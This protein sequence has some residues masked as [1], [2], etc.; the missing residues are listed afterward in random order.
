MLNQHIIDEFKKNFEYQPTAGQEALMVSLANFVLNNGRR[1][2][3]LIKGYAGTGKTTLLSSF[4][5]TLKT[6]NQKSVLLAPTGRA[7]K[8]FSSYSGTPAFTVHKI[9][10]RQKSST[11]SFGTF[12]LNKN[13]LSNTFFIVDEASMIGNQSY[14]HSIFGSGNLLSDLI[15]FVYNDKNCRLIFIGDTAQLPPVGLDISPALN[16]EVVE[17]YNLEVEEVFLSDVVRQ[18]AES[19]ILFNA[20]EVRNMVS[21][22]KAETPKIKLTG[23]PDIRRIGGAEM[24]DEISSAYDKF[25]IEETMIITRSN[26]RA[27]QFNQGIRSQ[28]LF[29]EEQ[30]TKGDYLMVVKNNYFWSEGN[31][32][33]DFIANGDIVQITAI[34]KYEER[35]GFHY[36]DITVRLIDY[37]DV[38][39][40]VKVILDS[41]VVESASLSA[42]DNKKLFYSV[43]EDYAEVEP[44]KKRFDK[45]KADPYFNALQVKFAYAVTCH[46]SQGG[47]WKAVFVDQ[48][49]FVD[50]MLNIEYLRWLYTA[51]TRATEK[52][53]LVN[54]KDEFFKS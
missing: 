12:A 27:N 37:E 3:M 53:Y 20:T 24:I 40:N 4:V 2:A 48:G 49:Y 10:Y 23:Y 14:E 22:K 21:S 13:L 45:V 26:K 15:D 42:E 38:E 11:D 6:L 32:K 9:I 41:I 31:E 5:K 28:I 39:I 52:L 50:D 17:E 46:K 36:A 16:K 25:G 19:G 30:I 18:A 43:L 8:V 54:F 47:Q 7:A 51:L 29:R 35:Y 44:K 33:L 34:K 1:N